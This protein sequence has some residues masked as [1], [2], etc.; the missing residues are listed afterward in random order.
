[1]FDRFDDRTLEIA[2]VIVVVLIALVILCYLAI[3]INPQVPFNPWKPE[4][5]VADVTPSPTPTWET[6]TPSPT[7]SITPT[8]TP[9][10]TWTPTPTATDTATPTATWTPTATETKPAPTPTNTRR[11]RP[12]VPTSTPTP[13]PYF[14]EYAGGRPNC[15]Y[16]MVWGYVAGANGLGEDDVQMQVGND[17]GWATDTWTDENGLYAFHLADGPKEGKWFVRVYKG[18]VPRSEQFWWETSAGCEGPYSLQEVRI[19]WKHW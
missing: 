10:A 2:T 5:E 3:Y 19:D 12:R 4:L 8:H 16:T 17:Q 11:P 7:P 9:T 18:G 14:Y 13:M 6:W 1:M 15:E